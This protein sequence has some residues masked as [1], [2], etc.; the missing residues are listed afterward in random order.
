MPTHGLNYQVLAES[1]THYLLENRDT[2]EIVEWEII[3][4]GDHWPT[5]AGFEIREVELTQQ[6]IPR[7]Q[8]HTSSSAESC[9]SEMALAECS[10]KA[11]TSLSAFGSSTITTTRFIN[12]HP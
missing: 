4:E 1:V 10:E 3:F 11:F 12:W 2:N 9:H 6:H 7:V 5:L 8:V